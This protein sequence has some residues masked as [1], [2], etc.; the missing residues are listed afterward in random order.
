MVAQP[1]QI[2]FDYLELRLPAFASEVFEFLGEVGIDIS[3]LE[4]DHIG[5]RVN[6]QETADRLKSELLKKRAALPI[7]SLNRIQVLSKHF[8]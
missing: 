4:I 5:F 2:T 3:G 7:R 6:S 8:M 1:S